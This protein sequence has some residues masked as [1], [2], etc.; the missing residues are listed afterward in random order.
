MLGEGSGEVGELVKQLLWKREDLSSDP[1][2]HVKA[3]HGGRHL[4]CQRCGTETG[5]PQSSPEGKL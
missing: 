2:T 5:R 1:S 4:I 3:E